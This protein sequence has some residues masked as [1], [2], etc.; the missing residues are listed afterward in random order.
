MKAILR[1]PAAYRLL[2]A[3]FGTARMRRF[4]AAEFIRAQAGARV[5]DIGCGTADI[6]EYLPQVSYFGIDY[7]PNYIEYNRRRFPNAQFEV[8]S[9]GPELRNLLPPADIVMANAILHHLSDEEA[10]SLFDTAKNLMCEGGRLVT[11]DNQFRARQNPVAR[12]LIKHD[13]GR[14]VRTREQYEALAAPHF[15]SMRCVESSRLLRVPYDI[16]M[17]E[18]MHPQL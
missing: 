18:F 9:V 5:V 8:A 16:I 6:L 1:L 12:F 11:L 3:F 17:F 2:H 7:N 10:S 4:Y 15:R 13:R 14:F